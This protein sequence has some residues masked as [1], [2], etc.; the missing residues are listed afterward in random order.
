MKSV[1]CV[2]PPVLFLFASS[3]ALSQSVVQVSRTATILNK[4]ETYRGNMQLIEAMGKQLEEFQIEATSKIVARL[5]LYESYQDAVESERGKGITDIS[6]STWETALQ[7]ARK[8]AQP[9]AEYVRIGN[10]ANI[11][12]FDGKVSRTQAVRGT[13]SLNQGLCTDCKL[14]F[15]YLTCRKDK[16]T[17]R[18][19]IDVYFWY[20][21]RF[22]MSQAES[23]TRA[24]GLASVPLTSVYYSND[25]R[26]LLSTS[27]P[28]FNR[29]INKELYGTILKQNARDVICN[30]SYNGQLRCEEL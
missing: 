28:Y 14:E 8:Q 3:L 5:T 16:L 29:F 13:L 11:R 10:R 2:S 22:T 25:P 20:G 30:V 17:L 9:A 24:L 21:G 7:T 23:A 15:L 4:V 18:V 1:H 6:L 27:Y 26:Y 19:G 12:V